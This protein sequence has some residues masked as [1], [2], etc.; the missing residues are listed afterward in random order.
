MPA[1]TCSVPSDKESTAV[2]KP[3]ERELVRRL[4][5]GDGDALEALLRLYWEG[6]VRYTVHIVRS[7]DQAEDVAQEA[8]VRL[9][10]SRQRWRE[11]PSIRPV[12][13][14]I[15]RNLALNEVRRHGTF[16]R[17]L[18][19]NTADASPADPSPGPFQDMVSTE[20]DAAMRRA[21]DALPE[22]RREI[23]ILVRFHQMSHR[24]AGEVL[25]I[26]AQAV[27]NQM[28]RALSD[29]HAALDPLLEGDSAQHVEFPL[30]RTTA[31]AGRFPLE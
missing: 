17:W 30:S 24:E 14:R 19:R 4:G 20:L 29:L 25:G 23:F 31:H 10:T 28:S 11:L 26:S 18:R 9:W 27:S 21:V 7:Q 1:I 13:Y 16:E 8:F 2:S 12:L 5:Q 22:R 6:I 3:A 15:A